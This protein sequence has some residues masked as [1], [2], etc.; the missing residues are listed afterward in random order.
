MLR[1]RLA[2]EGNER[3]RN[4]F[5]PNQALPPNYVRA[6]RLD[7]GDICHQS[8]QKFFS[9]VVPARGNPLHM[10][11]IE[12]GCVF[13]HGLGCIL[14]LCY[15]FIFVPQCT[16]KEDSPVPCS[17]D[18]LLTCPRVP[19]SR[20]FPP[21]FFFLIRRVIVLACCDDGYCGTHNGII[22]GTID[23]NIAFA[24]DVIST[25][26]HGSDGIEPSVYNSFS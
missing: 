14:F 1:P 12:G 22:H 7:G 4:G 5:W 10:L 8:K 11:R 6:G 19:H 20:F 16:R 2:S 13:L 15:N 23:A 3:N 18:I 24:N 25:T 17:I 26:K 21:Y 9:I